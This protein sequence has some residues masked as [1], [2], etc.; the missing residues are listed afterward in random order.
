MTEK[1]VMLAQAGELVALRAA[2]GSG[3][4][5]TLVGIGPEGYPAA[6]TISISQAEGIRWL[7]F[8][9]GAGSPITQCLLANPK[10]CVCLNGPDHHIAL[11]GDVEVCNDLETRR[12]M[13]YDGLENHFSG[14]EDEN[15]RV[16]RFT[17]RRYS[18]F[19]NWED[20]KGEI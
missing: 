19:I 2:G 16:L 5:C 20:L 10:A 3:N 1:K 12:E 9:T 4:Y 17:T 8:C 6:T 18:L 7:T 15:F 14:P 11:T 13:W